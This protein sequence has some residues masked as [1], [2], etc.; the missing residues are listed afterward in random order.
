MVLAADS[1]KAVAASADER[2]V[3]RSIAGQSASCPEVVLRSVCRTTIL[4]M[5]L[6]WTEKI[7]I[8]TLRLPAGWPGFR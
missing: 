2:A 8:D 7:G 1:W 4:G 6:V 5:L 3:R